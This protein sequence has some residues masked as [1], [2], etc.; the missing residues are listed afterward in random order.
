MRAI[1]AIGATIQYGAGKHNTMNAVE[2]I[3]VD[4]SDAKA[5]GPTSATRLRRR[6]LWLG[7]VLITLIVGADVYE[8]WQ[9]RLTALRRSQQTIDLLSKAFADQTGR[10]LQ[11]LDFSLQDLAKL[12]RVQPA[13]GLTPA[14]LQQ[15]L[16]E[17]LLRLPYVHSVSVFGVDGR[18]IVSTDNTQASSGR[19]G[20]ALIFTVPERA[21]DDALYVGK[22]WS[23]KEDGYRTF[24]VSRRLTDAQGQFSG[25]IVV[26]VAFEYLA[27]FYAAVNVSTGAEI[28]L[29]RSDSTELARYPSGISVLAGQSRPSAIHARQNVADYPLTL[30]VVQSRVNALGTWAEEE[31]ASAARTATLAVLAAALLAGLT[32]ALRR[33]DEAESAQQRSQLQLQDARKAEAVSLL[34]ASVAH[35]FNN[36]LSA[37]IGYAELAR[38]AAS[39]GSL[40]QARVDRLLSAAE[41]ARQLVGRVLTFDHHRS[42]KKEDVNVAPVLRDV[43]EHLRVTSPS[44]IRFEVDVPATEL[45]T[46]GDATEV[47]QVILNLCSNAIHSMPAGGPLRVALVPVTI[48]DARPLNVGMLE[49][50]EWLCISVVDQGVGIARERMNTIFDPLQT[51]RKSSAGHGI[52]LTVVRNVVVGMHGA[53]EVESVP[54]QGSRFSVYLRRSAERNAVVASLSDRRR[55]GRGQTLMILDD[56]PHLVAVVEELAASLGYEPVGYVDSSRAFEAIRHN[57]ARFDVVLT[58]ER[59]PGFN[60]TE[61][62]NAVHALHAELPIVLMTAYR[63][64]ELD[65]IARSSGIVQIVDKPVRLNEL[66]RA[67]GEALAHTGRTVNAGSEAYRESYS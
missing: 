3:S 2:S 13:Q 61:F 40:V 7:I 39:P 33:R 52:G 57:P 46:Y 22:L 49:P 63:S 35:D 30:E 67:L 55:S 36:V 24:A 1:D 48:A 32:R 41:R 23:S 14:E 58:D 27:R 26:R 11:Q 10:M 18:R 50:G 56:E 60:G 19:I 38:V 65:V 45:A 9:D 37:I 8:G 59:M 54:T 17:R 34:A 64:A 5:N 15:T 62:A 4:A 51:S 28:R 20:H 29:V 25:V 42:V 43:V 66:A 31:K 12:L 16:R 44:E 21:A 53:V 6:V 47:Y